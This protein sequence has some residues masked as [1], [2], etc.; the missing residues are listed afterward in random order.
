MYSGLEGLQTYWREGWHW[1]AAR[2]LRN[3]GI[4]K[5]ETLNFLIFDSNWIIL[6]NFC[7][8]S[9]FT[10]SV[11]L[12]IASSRS[13]TC[14]S[15][16]LTSSIIFC[17][18]KYIFDMVLCFFCVGTHQFHSLKSISGPRSIEK[19]YPREWRI[20]IPAALMRVDYLSRGPEL[21]ASGGSVSSVVQFHRDLKLC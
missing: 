13:G 20:A 16:C 9:S 14:F 5:V 17:N 19:V 18:T 2:K 6:N 3:S 1:P 12:I 11:G 7:L 15:S 8:N 21:L 4:Q 10:G